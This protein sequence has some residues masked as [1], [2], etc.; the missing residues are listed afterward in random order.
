M[1]AIEVTRI[2]S[3]VLRR[4]G[5]RG[6]FR[7]RDKNGGRTILFA[8]AENP[9]LDANFMTLSFTEPELLPIEILHCGNREFGVLFAKNSGNY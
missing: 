3:V 9:A 8:I 6:H 2:Q 7:S 5:G 4:I 1:Y